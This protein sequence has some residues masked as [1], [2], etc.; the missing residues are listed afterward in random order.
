MYPENWSISNNSSDFLIATTATPSNAT[1][2]LK[3]QGYTVVNKSEF[4][5]NKSHHLGALYIKGHIFGVQKHK[6]DYRE[7][8][9]SLKNATPR[10]HHVKPLM[11][12][13]FISTGS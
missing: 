10:P 12:S 13:P 7:C 1:L 5:L 11:S 6:E 2:C 9:Y 4:F 8:G 3:V